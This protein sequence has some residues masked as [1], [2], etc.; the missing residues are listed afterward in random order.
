MTKNILGTPEKKIIKLGENE[1]RLSPLNLNVLAD[2]EEGFDCSIDKVGKMLD[3]KRAS[4]LRKLV[5]ILLKQ[6]YPDMTLEKIGG[7]IDLSNMAEISEA[8]A[9]VLAGD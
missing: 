6:E 4:A 3:K 5:Y 9:K 8:L 1:Y 7:F 2:I